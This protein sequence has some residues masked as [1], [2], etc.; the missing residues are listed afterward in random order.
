MTA[1]NP[2]A[3]FQQPAAQVVVAQPTPQ[4]QAAA[5]IAAV[6]DA[7]VVAPT[8]PPAPRFSLDPD[9]KYERV[10]YKG[11]SLAVRKPQLQA[12]AGFQLSAGKFISVEKQNNISGLFI[13]QHLAPET[14]DHVMQR[15]MDPDDEGYTMQTVAEIMGLLVDLAVAD[16]NKDK[17]PDAIPSNATSV[18]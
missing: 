6:T 9:W 13:D 2:D 14:Y 1:P 17:V 18:G 7:P 11:D 3:V 10:E 12:L 16:L 4:A 5:E 15:M 8:P